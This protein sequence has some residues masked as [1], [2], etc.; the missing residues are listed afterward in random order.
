MCYNL[1][2]P[3]LMLMMMMLILFISKEEEKKE[4]EGDE[5]K[6]AKQ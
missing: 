1:E 2:S 6:I 5:R 3:H 4:V